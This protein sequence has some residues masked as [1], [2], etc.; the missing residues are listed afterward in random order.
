MAAAA[1]CS[2]GTPPSPFTPLARAVISRDADEI[3]RLLHEGATVHTMD[4]NANG[5]PLLLCCSNGGLD[6]LHQLLPHCDVNRVFDG[7]HTALSRAFLRPAVVKVLLDAGATAASV[8]VNG[9]DVIHALVSRLEPQSQSQAYVPVGEPPEPSLEHF[10]QLIALFS[11]SGACLDGV[12]AAGQTAVSRLAQMKPTRPDRYGLGGF[13]PQAYIVVLMNA[14]ARTSVKDRAGHCAWYHILL[15]RAMDDASIAELL[16]ADGDSDGLSV[17]D[18]GGAYPADYELFTHGA[19]ERPAVME[20]LQ[21]RHAPSMFQSSEVLTQW[22]QLYHQIANGRSCSSALQA[23]T[24]K[25]LSRQRELAAVI[26]PFGNTLLHAVVAYAGCDPLPVERRS[27][28]GSY[29]SSPEVDKRNAPD[30]D[31]DAFISLLLQ[32]GCPVDARGVNP[33]QGPLAALSARGS[34]LTAA[35][36]AVMRLR[37]GT[38]KTLLAAGAS[39]NQL[40][41]TTDADEGCRLMHK[42]LDMEL[43]DDGAPERSTQIVAVARALIEQGKA[44]L[45][46]TDANGAT[47]AM[48]AAVSLATPLHSSDAATAAA[49]GAILTSLLS[50]PGGEEAFLTIGVVRSRAYSISTSIDNFRVASPAA[51][52]YRSASGKLVGETACA[53]SACASMKALCLRHLQQ[54]AEAAVA[55]DG[56]G[57]GSSSVVEGSSRGCGHSADD[58]AVLRGLADC[59]ACVS[60]QFTKKRWYNS[61]Y[62][63]VRPLPLAEEFVADHLAAI[64]PLLL[65]RAR[66]HP[67]CVGKDATHEYHWHCAAVWRHRDGDLSPHF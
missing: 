45:R 22:L 12:D 28:M 31:A 42:V 65:H 21:R 20:A 6:L 8:K 4:D 32:L 61:A 7:G 47:V 5:D 13:K 16:N 29:H 64:A 40:Y 43:N 39:V 54:A 51:M 41:D 26:D 3:K 62:V 57:G 11:T 56:L 38:L 34:R 59:V 1:S 53:C 14:G 23:F 58:V 36:L 10:S 24:A 37:D 2:G 60:V 17:Q 30:L 50:S 27:W 25:P 9:E 48:N 18:G 63:G 44:D 19:G 66:F 55:Y 49:A 15:N 33:W 35:G 46:A 52:L 67:P